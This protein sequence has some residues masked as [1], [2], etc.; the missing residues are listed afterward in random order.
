MFDTYKTTAFPGFR[1][2]NNLC[3]FRL[4]PEPQLQFYKCPT[5]P[6]FYFLFWFFR[7]WIGSFQH[8]EKVEARAFFPSK[9]FAHDVSNSPAKTEQLAT[10]TNSIRNPPGRKDPRRHLILLRAHPHWKDVWALGRPITNVRKSIWENGNP[11]GGLTS[12]LV[13]TLPQK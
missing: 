1:F 4:E 3:R 6:I 2:H 7:F 10:H 11:G 9:T 8:T 13:E 5:A 12:P